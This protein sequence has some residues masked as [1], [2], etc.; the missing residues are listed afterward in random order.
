M[1]FLETNHRRPSKFL[2]DQGNKRNWWKYNKKRFGSGEMKEDKVELFN[3]LL[4]LGEQN[5]HV[6]Q[7]RLVTIQI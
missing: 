4:A 7:Y 6:N 2:P 3:L 1:L 5:K